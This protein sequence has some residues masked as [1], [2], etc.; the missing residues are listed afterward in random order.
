[1]VEER[2]LELAQ[3]KVLTSM[4]PKLLKRIEKRWF[5][6]AYGFR[7][8]KTASEEAKKRLFAYDLQTFQ[9]GGCK[10]FASW[11]DFGLC[12]NLTSPMDG[13]ITVEHAGCYEHSGLTRILG[14]E[15]KIGYSVK[16]F[17]NDGRF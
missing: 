11:Q 9:C 8:D 6:R 7:A 16:D 4:N 1:M 17:V 2:E 3:L 14:I 5:R 15:I 10:F 12:C 13:R